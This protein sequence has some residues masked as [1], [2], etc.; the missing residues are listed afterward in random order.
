MT[1]SLR[2]ANNTIYT[3]NILAADGKEVMRMAGC[4]GNISSLNVSNLAGG[5]YMAV[6]KD[7]SGNKVFG[8]F[9]KQ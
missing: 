1:I 6:V 4:V 9:I 7:A 2:E 3:L 8:K 5:V